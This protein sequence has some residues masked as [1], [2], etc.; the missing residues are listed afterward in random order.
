MSE[1]ILKYSASTY[2]AKINSLDSLVSRLSGH[3]S[4]LEGL[5]SQIPSF[6][7]DADAAK[8]TQQISE[9]IIAVRHSME[10]TQ[11]L[12]QLYQ[13]NMDQMSRASEAIDDTLDTVSDA[14]KAAGV[15]GML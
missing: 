7:D 11:N 13:E 15:I 4:T 12:K 9:Q 10:E 2:Q 14:M 6:W 1:V 8:Y 5:K 3:L